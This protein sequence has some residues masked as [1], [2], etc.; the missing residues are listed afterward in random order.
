MAVSSALRASRPATL[1]LM[2]NP[3]DAPLWSS[4]QQTLATDVEVR[5]RFQ[6]LPYVLRSS[7]SETGFTQPREY[8]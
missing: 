6:A 1:F 2:K 5:D 4:A 8:N 3:G 7:G